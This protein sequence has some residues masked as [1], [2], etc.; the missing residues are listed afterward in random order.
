MKKK[1]DLTADYVRSI[2]MLL[3]IM[4]HTIANSNLTGYENSLLFKIIWVLQ[5]PLFMLISGYVT[6][7]AK[8]MESFHD[9]VKYIGKKSLTLLLPWAVWTIGV[10]GFLLGGWTV[11]NFLQKI[12]HLLWHMDSGYWFLTS[13]WSI[14]MLW[15]IAVFVCRKAFP[16]NTLSKAFFTAAV[17]ALL[18]SVLLITGF[19]AGFSF[20]GI[21]LSCYYLPFFLLGCVFPY[22]RSAVSSKKG[23]ALWERIII[24]ALLIVSSCLVISRNFYTTED[25]VSIIFT[26]IICSI[27]GCAVLAYCAHYLQSVHF[28][29]EK[30]ALLWIG[31]HTLELYLCHNLFIGIID[32]G[33]AMLNSVTGAAVALANFCI[34]LL[35]ASAAAAALGWNRFT[36]LIFFGKY[37]AAVKA[38]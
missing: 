16:G 37:S 32:G 28:R 5:M 38:Q 11:H 4:G 33:G 7:F 36:R 15:G 2:A 31:S 14:Q 26:R 24:C 12:N 23:Y 3:V 8:P 19:F 1:R 22:F 17:T 10:R 30:T 34:T 27:S 29:K 13:L 20:F 25:S 9:L 6:Y 35:L 18:S 21:K